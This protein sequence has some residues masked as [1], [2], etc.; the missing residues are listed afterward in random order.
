MLLH[1]PLFPSI[2]KD[3]HMVFIPIHPEKLTICF[4]CKNLIKCDWSESLKRYICSSCR[5]SRKS[6]GTKNTLIKGNKQGRLPEYSL[7]FEI[8]EPERTGGERNAG[9]HPT[10]QLEAAMRLLRYQFLRTADGT[11]SD[12]YK[13]P[14][15]RSLTAFYPSL[16][17]MDKLQHLVGENC[18][19]HLHVGCTVKKLLQI[20]LGEIFGPLTTRMVN[21]PEET[22]VFWGR[23]FNEW[24]MPYP[25]GR[26]YLFNVCTEHPTLEYRLPR[27]REK[28]QYLAI[29]KF[30]RACSHLLNKKMPI[31]KEKPEF[32][33]T[34][35]QEIV[36]LYQTFLPSGPTWLDRLTKE[37]QE[38]LLK[39]CD[40][41]TWST[42]L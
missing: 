4:T 24:A 25:R 30:A 10:V 11:V 8:E 16:Q 3:L 21:C 9:I 12:E 19:T 34:L 2:R 14:V 18:G 22:L 5:S 41:F 6:Y 38:S 29:I 15:F 33:P 20:Y 35:G 17:V 40:A 39:K 26:Y 1:L 7:E 23:S 31:V 42:C 13:S 27:F 28:G 32:L 37:E 36:T